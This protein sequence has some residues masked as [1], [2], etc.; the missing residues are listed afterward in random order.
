[1][2]VRM[3]TIGIVGSRRRLGPKV[4]RAIERKLLELY[5]EDDRLV[6]GGC[7]E[8]ADSYAEILAKKT[9]NSYNDS[10]RQVEKEGKFCGIH[11]KY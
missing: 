9:P 2:Q 6:S 7:K 8:G 5:E 3:K 10:L 11:K 4:F 1:M